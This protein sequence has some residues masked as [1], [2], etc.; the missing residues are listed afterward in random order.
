MA[1]WHPVSTAFKSSLTDKLACEFD[2]GNDKVVFP[3]VNLQIAQSTSIG[4][5]C[6]AE[7]PK[8]ILKQAR[9]S[10]FDDANDFG[11]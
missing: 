7:R 4:R 3:N 2:A 1:S 6:P 9:L 11:S 10:F 8:I 5:N